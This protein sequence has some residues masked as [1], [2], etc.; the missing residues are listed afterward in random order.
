MYVYSLL[1]FSNKMDSICSMGIEPEGDRITLW[2]IEM[3]PSDDFGR[4][5][6]RSPNVASILFQQ[7]WI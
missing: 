1:Y 7:M 3:Y 5:A 6:K 4:W 2:E